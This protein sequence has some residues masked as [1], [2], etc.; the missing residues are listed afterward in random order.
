MHRARGLGVVQPHARLRHVAK[1]AELPALLLLRRRP[2]EHHAQL[3]MPIG[4]TAVRAHAC[5][6]QAV[7]QRGEPLRVSTLPADGAPDRAEPLLA[8]AAGSHGPTI[9]EPRLLGAED[10]VD[11]MVLKGWAAPAK[12]H[13]DCVAGLGGL[14]PTGLTKKFA[15]VRMP[16][17][18][19]IKA[20]SPTSAATP[21]DPRAPAAGDRSALVI[22]SRRVRSRGSRGLTL[23][24][25]RLTARR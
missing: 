25:A 22:R 19:T 15:I 1:A 9:R 12:L 7:E 16:E 10:R 6:A 21:T 2:G 4:G 11:E 18:T 23:R 14:R 8:P 24:H 5:L 13:T 17:H 20:R 3:S